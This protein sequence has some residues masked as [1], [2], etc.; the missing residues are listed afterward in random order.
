MISVALKFIYL[1]IAAGLGVAGLK[2]SSI[3]NRNIIVPIIFFIVAYF[4]AFWG[5]LSLFQESEGYPSTVVL[6]LT[7]VPLWVAVV[8][9]VINIKKS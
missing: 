8:V 7:S 6:Y 1:T 2:Y 3:S 9:L 4:F 5:V